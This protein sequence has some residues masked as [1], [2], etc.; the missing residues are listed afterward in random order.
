MK[1][2]S[3]FLILVS[4]L[5]GVTFV[6]ESAGLA[7]Q[8][9]TPIPT[10]SA[11]PGAVVT[12]T[13]TPT[14]A[15]PTAIP[16]NTPRPS[17]TPVE[18]GH[19]WFGRP[20]IR[21]YSGAIMDYPARGYAYGS[22]AGGGLN[23]HH[24]IDIENGYGTHIQAVASGT[25]F[26]AGSD[27]SVMFGPQLDFYGNLVVIQHNVTAPDGRPLF[28][29]YG[30]ISRWMVETGDTVKIG[31]TIAAVGSEGVAFGPHLHFEVRI[32]DP[33]SYAATYNPELW[34]VPWEGHGVF[35][36]RVVDATGKPVHG[37]RLELIGQGRFFSGWTYA[38]G[39]VNSDPYWQ[40]NI[41][42][43]DMPA[44]TYDLKVGE[45][46]NILYKG[47]ITIEEG[48]VS[49]IEIQL[50]SVITSSAG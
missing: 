26:Y 5:I 17:P 46:R 48:K 19:F 38:E 1:F 20:F 40:E 47:E 15:P 30:H 31:D 24:G 41:V 4:I 50:P 21:D 14:Y 28:S 45:A 18:N 43:G 33:Y 23:I 42:I 34:T 16:T 36:A 6:A 29:L 35:A 22:T 37:V 25:V 3:V 2:L 27:A 8:S 9:P 32:G 7:V 13:P 11:I 49:F 12:F 39:T 44:G 10:V